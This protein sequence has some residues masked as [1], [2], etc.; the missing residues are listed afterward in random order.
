MMRDYSYHTKLIFRTSAGSVSIPAGET[1]RLTASLQCGI[2]VSRYETIR[3]YCV[4]RTGSAVPVT[5][6][7]HALDCKADELLFV[8]DNFSLSAG[9]TTTRVYEVPA[10][11]LAVFAQAGTG[12]GNTAIDFGVFGFGPVDCFRQE[13]PEYYYRHSK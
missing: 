5:L 9:Q 1:V 4:C 11:A 13:H 3:I 6:F 7:I 10:E 12:S 2:S 8:L